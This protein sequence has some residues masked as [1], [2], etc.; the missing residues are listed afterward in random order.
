MRVICC[1]GAGSRPRPIRV[2]TP[3]RPVNETVLALPAAAN[4]MR[5]HWVRNLLSVLQSVHDAFKVLR[6][7]NVNLTTVLQQLCDA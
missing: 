5:L 2:S 1:G 6:S 7:P 4:L 3:Y